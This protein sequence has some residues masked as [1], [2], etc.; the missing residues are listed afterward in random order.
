MSYYAVCHD[1]HSISIEEWD[2]NG[3][4]LSRPHHIPA[5]IHDGK[6]SL[7]A[8]SSW[9]M[10]PQVGHHPATAEHLYD[11]YHASGEYASPCLIMR[12][13]AR[14]SDRPV[15]FAV[16]ASRYD[17]EFQHCGLFCIEHGLEHLK[18]GGYLGLRQ[19][20]AHGIGGDIWCRRMP[21]SPNRRSPDHTAKSEIGNIRAAAAD[22]KWDSSR[23]RAS[24]IIA[25]IT[26]RNTRSY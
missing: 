7:R 11:G 13:L 21:A 4:M 24:G 2:L 25:G 16:V 23:A 14:W 20:M 12:A 22:K 26:P 8:L 10:P 18:R 15:P 6:A 5:G 9:R 17:M 19:W 3:F 1:R